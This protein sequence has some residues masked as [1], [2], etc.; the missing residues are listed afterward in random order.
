[1][2]GGNPVKRHSRVAFESPT[3]RPHSPEGAAAAPAGGDAAA[4]YVPL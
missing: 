3:A 1:M 2:P 4:A